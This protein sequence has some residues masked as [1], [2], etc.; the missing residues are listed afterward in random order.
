[1]KIYKESHEGKHATS[2]DNDGLIHDHLLN[3]S[4]DDNVSLSTPWTWYAPYKIQ[5]P[6]EVTLTMNH[7][8]TCEVILIRFTI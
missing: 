7:S 4:C 3:P 5:L 2:S 8:S 1:M 6:C